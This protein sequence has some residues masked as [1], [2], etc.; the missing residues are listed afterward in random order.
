M[1]ILSVILLFV[2]CSFKPV[3]EP[4]IDASADANRICGKW[5]S[6][7]KNLVVEVYPYKGTYRAKMIHFTGG[8][9][10]DKPMESITDK[11]NPD[12]TLRNR[13]V[14]GMD[15]VENLKFNPKSNSWEGGRIYEVQSG[16]Y[17]SAAASLDGSGTLKVKGYW[18]VKLL[19]RTM[20][21]HRI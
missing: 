8:V 3:T 1:R 17:W 4:D 15:V 21:F 13:K 7:E 11:K 5:E 20:V 16:K 19:G 6:S 14:L 18:K 9:T 2:L 10:K 12:P